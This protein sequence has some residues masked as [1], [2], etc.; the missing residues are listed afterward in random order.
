MVFHQQ[1]VRRDQGNPD[2]IEV[3]QIF[4]KFPANKYQIVRIK[5]CKIPACRQPLRPV[6]WV[7]MRVEAAAL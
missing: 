5:F 1:L 3:N 7:A 2:L 4:R 6:L